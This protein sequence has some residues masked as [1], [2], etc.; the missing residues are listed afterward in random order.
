MKKFLFYIFTICAILSCTDNGLYSVSGQILL[1]D[2]PISDAIISIDNNSNWNTTTDKNGNYIIK[3]ISSGKHNLSIRYSHKAVSITKSNTGKNQVKTSNNDSTS[4]VEI[5]KEISV[6]QDL[7]LASL[8]LPKPVIMFP[9]I[10]TTES[11][12]EIKWS[13]TDAEDFRE[14]KLY[15]HTTS[16]LDETTG[17]LVHVS[18]S[19]NDTMFVDS[20]LSPLTNYYYRIYIMNDYGKL[21]GSNILSSQTMAKNYVINGDFE[22]GQDIFSSW[23]KFNTDGEIYFCDSTKKS[24]NRSLCLHAIEK[25]E[26]GRTLTR[27]QLLIGLKTGLDKTKSYKASFWIKTSGEISKNKTWSLY[28]YDDYVAGIEGGI[29]LPSAIGIK[30]T[31]TDWTYVEKVIPESYMGIQD[32]YIRSFCTYTWIDDLR[33]ED[34]S[35]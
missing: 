27:A 8:K 4:Y 28:G 24:G 16:G 20:K 9:I 12:I 29:S 5:N 21:G 2:V 1:G 23:E 7:V 34:V 26:Y 17:E 22:S 6:Y 19:K 35:K 25:T 11:S 15:R 13:T 30:T 18:T 33:I 31:N 3:G 32:V 10:G 14:Y